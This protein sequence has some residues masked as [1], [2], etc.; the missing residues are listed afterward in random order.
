MR[1]KVSTIME[2]SLFRQVRFESVKQGKQISE[3]IA[4]A[5]KLYLDTIGHRPS[6]DSVVAETWGCLAMQVPQVQQILEEEDG[7]LDP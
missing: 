6:R 4:E 5:L 3:I 1:R 7:L 2:A